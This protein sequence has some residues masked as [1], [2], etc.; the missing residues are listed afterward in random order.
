MPTNLPRLSNIIAGSA[1]PG[2][3]RARSRSVIAV[4]HALLSVGHGARRRRHRRGRGRQPLSRFQR[5]HRGGGHR[6]LPSAC[7]QSHPGAG[8]DIPPHVGHRFLL[9]EHGRARREARRTR[10]RRRAAAR[11]LRQLRRGSRRGRDEAGPLPHRPREVHRLL[12][13]LPRPHHG[14]AFAD[15]QQ[16]RPEERIRSAG[17]RRASRALPE[18]LPLPLRNDARQLRRRMRPA[19]R[20]DVLD[21]SPRRGDGGH[22]RRAGAGRRRLHRAAAEILRRAAGARATPGILLVFD[23]VQSGMGRTG[24]MLAAEHFDAMPD[25][26]AVAK[27]IASG[28]PLAPPSRARR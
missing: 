14:C 6:P 1:R 26:F 28:L 8:R 20:R 12:R 27:G 25:I 4:L 22:R 19:H 13:Q 11:V 9:R 15:R 24:K 10:A 2:D 18:L 17:A 7:R 23:E 5:R 21:T 16:G 3:H